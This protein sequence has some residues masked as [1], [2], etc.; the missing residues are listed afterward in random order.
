MHGFGVGWDSIVVLAE[1]F[2]DE[3]DWKQNVYPEKIPSVGW[4]DLVLFSL[5][6]ELY[7]LDHFLQN[8]SHR[9]DFRDYRLSS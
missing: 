3:K 2:D 8:I 4:N 7:L 1:I 5:V 6:S 9:R